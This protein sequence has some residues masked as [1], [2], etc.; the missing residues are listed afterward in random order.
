MDQGTVTSKGQLVI[1]APLRKKYGIKKG[2]KVAFIEQG[3]KILLQPIT[4][5]FI[6]SLRGILKSD[7]SAVQDLVDERRRDLER[8]EKKLARFGIR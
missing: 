4:K 5:E 1:P 3:N 6:R 7:G 2:T 8:E